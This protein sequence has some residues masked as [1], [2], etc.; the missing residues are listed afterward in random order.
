[1]G[2]AATHDDRE[3]AGSPAR[4]RERP[5]CE[6][7]FIGQC[8]DLAPRGPGKQRCGREGAGFFIRI[9]DDFETET[10]RRT[11]GLHRLKRGQHDRKATLH[12]CGPGAVQGP[13]AAILRCLKWVIDRIDRI[14]MT[15][16]KHTHR[17][18][19]ANAD[20]QMAAMMKF[21]DPPLFIDC[22]M[23]VTLDQFKI[24]GQDRKS[25]SKHACHP[26]QSVKIARTAVDRAPLLHLLVQLIILNARNCTAFV[27]VQHRAKLAQIAY[28]PKCPSEAVDE[29]CP[30]RRVRRY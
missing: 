16:E 30:A 19:R 12:I 18:F 9:D 15:G 24:A 1:M 2:A 8:C 21:F 25:I 17:R 27:R 6:R 5:V 28:A 29:R 14:H 10:P 22:T 3:I 20:V 26:V 23:P 11:A 7:G 4:P 13:I